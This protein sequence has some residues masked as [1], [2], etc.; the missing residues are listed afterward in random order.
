MK[1]KKIKVAILAS[2]G[3]VGGL[4]FLKKRKGGM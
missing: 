3:L 4:I 2:L 1:N